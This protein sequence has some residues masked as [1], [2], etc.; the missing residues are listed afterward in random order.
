MAELLNVSPGSLARAQTPL[1]HYYG[2]MYHQ[3]FL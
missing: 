2:I 3:L 1:L